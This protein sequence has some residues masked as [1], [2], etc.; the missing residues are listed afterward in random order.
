MKRFLAALPLLALYLTHVDLWFWNDASEFGG[1]PIGL[2]YHVAACFL[3]VAA[4]AVLVR[5]AWPHRLVAAAESDAELS[6]SSSAVPAEE[7]PNSG[8]SV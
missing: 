5:W 1:L 4:L 3:A 8:V 6:G 2:S 7:R